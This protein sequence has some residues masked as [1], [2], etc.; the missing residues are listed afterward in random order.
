VCTLIPFVVQFLIPDY[1]FCVCAHIVRSVVTG[2]RNY[3]FHCSRVYQ[4]WLIGQ[5]HELL[6]VRV[7]CRVLLVGLAACSSN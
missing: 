3:P 7:N 2:K 4:L 1:F 6:I 5:I